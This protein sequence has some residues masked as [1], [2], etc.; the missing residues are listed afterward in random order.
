MSVQARRQAR[1]SALQ[2]LYEIDSTDHTPAD[3]VANRIEDTPLPADGETFL[4]DLVAGVMKHRDQLDRLIQKYAPAWPVAQIAV[5]D[6][7]ILRLALYELSGASGTPPVSDA[8]TWSGGFSAS[9]APPKRPIEA[10]TI[11]R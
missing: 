3:V 11:V 6:R 2:A 5:V 8:S 7:N 4:R 10:N 9:Q 1:I